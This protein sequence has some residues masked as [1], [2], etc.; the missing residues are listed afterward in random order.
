MVVFPISMKKVGKIDCIFILCLQ[1]Y[2]LELIKMWVP[3]LAW[4]SLNIFPSTNPW[5]LESLYIYFKLEKNKPMGLNKE[6]CFD[7]LTYGEVYPSRQPSFPYF[8]DC[9]SLTPGSVVCPDISPLKH[10]LTD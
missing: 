3:I 10:R 6:K 2:L 1:G 4:L 5:Y 8:H 7:L 9:G